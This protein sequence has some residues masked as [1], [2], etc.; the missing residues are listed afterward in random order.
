M[1]RSIKKSLVFLDA[2]DIK[3]GEQVPFFKASNSVYFA[4]LEEPVGLPRLLPL[5]VSLK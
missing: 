2:V 4:L 3:K 5:R 1:G